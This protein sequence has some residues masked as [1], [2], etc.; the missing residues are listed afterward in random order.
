ML[1]RIVP[2]LAVLALVPAP[3]ASAQAPVPTTCVDPPPCVY[4]TPDPEVVRAPGTIYV[5]RGRGWQ[6][7]ARVTA[8]YGSYCDPKFDLCAGVGLSRSFRANPQGRFIFRLRYGNNVKLGTPQ[9]A[10]AGSEQESIRFFSDSLAD[11]DPEGFGRDAI[12]PPPPSTPEQRAEAL[13]VRDAV[14]R[15]TRAI[16]PTDDAVA[17]SMR[18]YEDNISGCQK[19][20]SRFEDRS[21]RGRTVSVLIGLAFDG[22]M[23][24]PVLP[25]LEAFARELEALTL[26]DPVLRAGADAWIAAV[27]RPRPWPSPDLC[28]VMRRWK[29]TG[30][31]LARAPADRRWGDGA[32]LGEEVTTQPAIRAA[33]THLRGLGA[34]RSA[35][36][37]FRGELVDL[38][39]LLGDNL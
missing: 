24:A 3:D 23:I 1:S 33:S 11:E 39:V 29:Q 2:A 32:E 5:Y 20:L 12:P 18:R 27:R 37:R 6:P 15:A 28:T 22:A 35:E 4:V 10:G 25:Q 13:A 19:D 7:G 26:T 9:P 34:G 14:E 36:E 16:A 30:F 8:S 17:E 31:D 38:A 21:A